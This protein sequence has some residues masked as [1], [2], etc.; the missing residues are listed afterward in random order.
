MLVLLDDGMV[1]SDA[2]KA[3]LGEITMLSRQNYLHV[4][5]LPSQSQIEFGGRAPAP[6]IHKSLLPT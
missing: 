1:V 6:A 5:Q 4:E 3:K 2:E